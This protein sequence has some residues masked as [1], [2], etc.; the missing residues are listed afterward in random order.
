M[1][2]SKII[3]ISICIAILCGA[4]VFQSC[5]KNESKKALNEETY[6]LTEP[7]KFEN[8]FIFPVG[9]TLTLTADRIHFNLPVG[10]R[11]IARVYDNTKAGNVTP[12][13]VIMSSG[14][15]TCKCLNG[16]GGCSPFVKGDKTG[17]LMDEGCSLCQKTVNPLKV[18]LEILE[19]TVIDLNIQPKFITDADELKTIP[20]PSSLMFESEEV[21]KKL[22]DFLK[23]YNEDM[24]RLQY[25]NMENIPDDYSYVP[26]RFL[27]KLILA[28]VLKSR[29]LS[30]NLKSGMEANKDRYSCSCGAGS[31]CV[32]GQN[33]I[34]GIY[35]CDASTCTECTMREL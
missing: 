22:E 34:L 21:I 24:N 20:S 10:Y 2:A 33:R 8:L 31:G 3:L 18:S 16:V 13:V 1:K 7:N 19:A 12:K 27:G 30:A 4:I 28:P 25:I 11:L 14:A 32:Y 26:V 17:C 6:V 15:V 23:G 29:C 35:Y 5:K 9:T